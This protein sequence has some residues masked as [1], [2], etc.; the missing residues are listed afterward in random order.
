LTQRGLG[1]STIAD[2]PRAQAQTTIVTRPATRST[3]EQ[4]ASTLG[5]PSSRVTEGTPAS[6]AD[7][8][9]TLGSDAR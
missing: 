4:V 3:A 6:G 1:V 2:A 7:I 5:V 8:E 9:V